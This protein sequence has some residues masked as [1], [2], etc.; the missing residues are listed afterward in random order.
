M[1]LRRRAWI[2]ALTL[3]SLSLPA[4]A[5]DVAPKPLTI[6]A[7][8]V[9]FSTGEDAKNT[10]GKLVH[11][12]TLRLTSPDGDFGGLSG[13]VVSADGTRF[14]AITDA[15]HWVTGK[16]S[17]RDGRLSGASGIEIG[18]L[19]GPDGAALSGKMGDAEGLGGALDGDVYVSFEGRHRIWRYDY[20]GDGM[21]GHA[22]V[23]ATPAELQGAPSNKGLEGITLLN[24]GRLLA[25]TE[26]YLDGAGNIRGWVLKEGAEAV[27]VLLKERPPF[28]LTDVRQLANGDVLTLERRFSTVGGVGFQMRRIPS[29]AFTAG[30]VLDGEVIADA[31]MNFMIDNM[32]GLSVRA[33]ANG[34][35]LLYIVSDDNFN[36]PLQQTLL[37]MFEL[38]N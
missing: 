28:D 37:M 11:R 31:G 35:T 14:L 26:S 12:G 6:E 1:T 5:Y 15:S 4:S 23:V 9:P 10:V 7:R 22:T 36:T 25:L 16:L 3:G 2:L 38:K 29:P 33:A 24:D 27:P 8:N 21:R 17:Y 34:E 18:P 30:E 20:A 13:L 19:I 32:E